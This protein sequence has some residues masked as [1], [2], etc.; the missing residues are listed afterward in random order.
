MTEVA[1]GND[2][3]LVISTIVVAAATI[4]TSIVITKPELK[5]NLI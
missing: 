5:N 3:N 4:T 2:P 1:I